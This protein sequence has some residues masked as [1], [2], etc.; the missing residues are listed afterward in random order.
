M[1]LNLIT[2][3]YNNISVC[4]DSSR[5]Q[6]AKELKEYIL[7]CRPTGIVLGKGAYSRV[8]ELKL[9]SDP[10]VTLAGKVFKT[11]HL[12]GKAID[13]H[14]KLKKEFEIMVQLKNS[15]IVAYKGV[16]FQPDA[17]LPL[18][19]MERMMTS[20]HD[21]LLKSDNSGLPVERKVS[22]LL[23][24]A[25][26]LEY[27]HSHTPAIIHRDLTAKN[28]LLDSQLRAKIADF[29]NSRIMKLRPLFGHETMTNEP[30][31]LAYMPPEASGEHAHYGPSLDVF[32]FGHLSLF[33]VIQS[34]VHPLL[35]HN[36]TDSVT[37]I[38]HARS[39]VE[40]REEFIRKAKELLSEDHFLLNLI[41]QCLSNLPKHRPSTAELVTRLKT[42]AG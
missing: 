22:F 24:T 35:P 16:C 13:Y 6:L 26:G 5:E 34:Q 9:E 39:E 17:M 14:E 36:Y 20:L 40:R 41:T 19:V 30:G 23:D 18:L 21:Y 1:S 7:S 32:S 10:S 25:S 27:L 28:M 15:N 4:A 29:G 31:T 2:T 38:L 12:S 33:T 8:I 11:S 42:A 3:L 37:G